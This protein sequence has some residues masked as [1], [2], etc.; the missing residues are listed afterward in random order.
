MR[1]SPNIFAVSATPYGPEDKFTGHLA[2]LVDNIPEIGQAWLDH[3]REGI[4]PDTFENAGKHADGTSQDMPDFLIRGRREDVICEHK[5]GAPLGPNQLERYLAFAKQRARSTRLALVSGGDAIVPTALIAPPEYLRPRHGAQPSF[6]WEE[7][8]PM[9]AG[10]P[11]RLAKEFTAYMEQ[12]GLRPC[13]TQEWSDLFSN[14]RRIDDFVPQW[15]DTIAYFKTKGASIV[16]HKT[17]TPSIQI[18][19][20]RPW[21]P[22]F[23]LKPVPRP[24]TPTDT[25]RGP[26]ISASVAVGLTSPIRLRFGGPET[27]LTETQLQVLSRPVPLAKGKN[28]A[29]AWCREYIAPLDAVVSADPTSMRKKLLEFAQIAFDDAVAIGEASF[30]ASHSSA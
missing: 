16:R 25:L 24:L 11:E 8:Y 7:L 3:L 22:Q 9:V 23:Y 17:A 27:F 2:Y 12:L 30:T 1:K 13:D 26:F 14:P 20:A 6:H 10:R 29:I 19:D 28:P 21:L 4:E 15:A 18:R 5:L